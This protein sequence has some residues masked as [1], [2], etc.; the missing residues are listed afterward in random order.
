VQKGLPLFLA[1]AAF[2]VASAASVQF[3]FRNLAV[4]TEDGFLA[5]TD[6]D[7]LIPEAMPPR[8][9]YG[10]RVVIEPFGTRVIR[11]AGEPGTPIVTASGEVIGTWTNF[12]R[13]H[14]VTTQPWN[15][16]GSLMHIYLGREDVSPNNLIL[17]GNGYKPLYAYYEPRRE[18]RWH[19]LLRSIRVQISGDTLSW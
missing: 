4:L 11:I 14:Y 19:P 7:V 13:Q 18:S 16:D 15:A 10:K 3:D 9:A 17:S 5:I 2:G 6:P 12:S 8:P 1:I